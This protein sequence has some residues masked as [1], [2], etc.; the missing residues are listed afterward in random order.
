[1]LLALR[2]RHLIIV[3]LILVVMILIPFMIG[4]GGYC[5]LGYIYVCDNHQCK[6]EPLKT[7]SIDE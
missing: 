3:L 5:G 2:N 4:C 7:M 1:M 6:C